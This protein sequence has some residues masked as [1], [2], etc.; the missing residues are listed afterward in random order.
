MWRV[1]RWGCSCKVA[2]F[3]FATR[4]E[5][6]IVEFCKKKQILALFP[7]RFSFSLTHFVLIQ[8]THLCDNILNSLSYLYKWICEESRM[9]HKMLC[10]F[11]FHFYIKCPISLSKSYYLITYLITLSH[12]FNKVIISE[13]NLAIVTTVKL[14]LDR[15]HVPIQ[16]DFS[17]LQLS[18]Q[19]LKGENSYKYINLIVTRTALQNTS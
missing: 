3:S 14:C 5:W 10:Y 15:Q 19:N 7:G 6:E 16:K 4:G 18:K 12:N 1:G 9:L 13:N 11:I 17:P 8:E 2:I